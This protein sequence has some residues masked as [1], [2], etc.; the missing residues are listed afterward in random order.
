MLWLFDNYNKYPD[1]LEQSLYSS[2][3]E[4]EIMDRR[5]VARKSISS[6]GR[7]EIR[8]VC[9]SALRMIKSDKPES[10]PIN[11]HSLTFTIV[12]RYLATFKRTIK[13]NGEIVEVRLNSSAYDSACSALS[14][15][16]TESGLDKSTVNPGLWLKLSSYKKCS[17]RMLA[18]QKKKFGLKL[19]ERKKP[20]SFQV[21]KKL[22]EILFKSNKNSDIPAQTFLVLEWNLISRAENCLTANISQIYF[23]QDSILFDFGKSKSDQE[24][25]KN[26]DHP[27]HLYANPLDPIVCPLVA[28]T[29]Y[30]FP[31]PNILKGEESLFEGVS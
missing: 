13:K 31:H 29:R 19:T 16:Y 8:S 1:V 10:I 17:R 26:I 21:Y 12:S 2:M 20:L 6:K 25:I 14:H 27:W 7:I 30:L 3:A 23:H 24:G 15:L 4:A 22:C 9:R 11:F 18:N 5:H 28:L